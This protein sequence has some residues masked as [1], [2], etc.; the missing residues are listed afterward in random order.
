MFLSFFKD[1]YKVASVIALCIVGFMGWRQYQE[2]RD[3]RR[4]SEEYVV[5]Y[6]VDCTRCDVI[7][8]DEHGEAPML[9][10]KNHYEETV[11]PRGNDEMK[12]AAINSSG[13][14]SLIKVM[15]YVD[16]KLYKTDSAFGGTVASVYFSPIDIYK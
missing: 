8:S 6:V 16:G 9:T 3:A 2:E 4:S 7:Y 13:E 5:K 1:R 12:V 11:F 10:G 15:V 14:K